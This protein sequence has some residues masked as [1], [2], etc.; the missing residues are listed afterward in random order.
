MTTTPQSSPDPFA[1]RVL[2]RI[3]DEHLAPRP[4][5]EFL[6]KNYFFW[7]L[8][9]LAVVL[10][11]LA[12]SAALFRI[13][14]AGWQ[15]SS[16][17]HGD[18]GQFIFDAAPVLWVVVFGVFLAIGYLNVRWT[19]HGYRYPLALIAIGAMLTSIALGAG[20]YATGLGGEIE[21]SIGDHPPFYRPI[22]VA[23]QSWWLSP[24][25]GLLGGQV[26]SADPET[27]SF[28][29]RDFSGNEWRIEEGELQDK[30][31]DALVVGNTVRIVGAPAATSSVFHACVVFP[32][33]A[34]R[35]F[36]ER[37]A[38]TL[39]LPP[40]SPNHERIASSSRTY[41]CKDIRSYKE[42]REID[43]TGL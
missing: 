35:A 41:V 4:R 27:A 5:W 21:E 42:L 31:R 11:A 16:V 18:L 3:V 32:W 1:R 30:D 28:V 36:R 19:I 38:P 15:L 25:K 29:L 12:F 7:T 40:A 20:L 17:T 10:G 37:L 2:N 6:F 26:I 39:H 24:G 8:G 33:R 43:A 9:V 34:F 23:Q 13:K 14:N 22:L